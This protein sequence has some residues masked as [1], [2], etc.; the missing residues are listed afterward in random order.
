VVIVHAIV[1]D[2]GEL[3]AVAVHAAVAAAVLADSPVAA[4]VKQ[5]RYMPTVSAF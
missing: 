4:S 3:E 2:S 5:L 1:V